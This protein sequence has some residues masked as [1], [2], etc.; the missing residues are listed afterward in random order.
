M[1]LPTTL[2]QNLAPAVSNGNYMETVDSQ[3]A[4]AEVQAAYTIAKRYPRNENECI[5]KI[6]NACKRRR[7]A[8]TA[9][10]SYP[11]GGTQVT[12]P[13]IRLAECL[14]KYWGNID[15]GFKVLSFD[16]TQSFVRAYC[17][18]LE[19]N[20]IK[21]IDFSVEHSRF[22]KRDGMVKLVDPRDI[23]EMIANQ[24]SRRVR[25]CILAVIPDD[26]KEEALEVCG[27]TLLK[28]AGD[29][30]LPDQIKK[31][32]LAFSEIGVTV[33]MLEKKLAHNMDA[34]NIQEIVTLRNI[35][36]SIKQGHASVSDHFE[37]IK[38]EAAQESLKPSQIF[39]KDNEEMRN[40]VIKTLKALEIEDIQST[41][42]DMHGKDL[43]A[44]LMRITEEL[45]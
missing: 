15:Y 26:I 12:G 38:K 39:D 4:I 36:N 41:L 13:S 28:A 35:Y 8:E 29:V 24:A 25:N 32:S 10:Y 33:A 42:E 31:V 6:V 40:T 22:T 14:A 16:A 3:R 45:S 9:M 11:R 7:L 17:N 44:E 30:P 5:V 2:N 1:N 19:T 20:T 18:D 23:Y 27:K 37:Y 21:K 34:T 43:Q